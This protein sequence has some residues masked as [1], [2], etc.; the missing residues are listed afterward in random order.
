MV[1]AVGRGARRRLTT[2]DITPGSVTTPTIATA[3]ATQQTKTVNAGSTSKTPG[4]TSDISGRSATQTISSTGSLVFVDFQGSA[5]LSNDDLSNVQIVEV[6]YNLTRGDNTV[7]V[8]GSIRLP[9]IAG[10]TGGTP[11]VVHYSEAGLSRSQT[12]KLRW[13]VSGSVNNSVGVTLSGGDTLTIVEF[14]R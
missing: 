2:A 12:Y 10:T 9:L 8:T 1:C 11:M 13:N 3:A 14:K 7:L 4:S 5:M 6:I